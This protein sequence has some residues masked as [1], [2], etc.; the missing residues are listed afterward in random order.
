MYQRERGELLAIGTLTHAGELLLNYVCPDRR[1][2]GI[3]KAML[4]HLESRAGELGVECCF[5]ETTVTAATFHRSAGYASSGVG[6][7]SKNAKAPSL[8]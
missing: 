1:F 2:Q 7:S 6:R 5:V 4:N 8:S 3:S